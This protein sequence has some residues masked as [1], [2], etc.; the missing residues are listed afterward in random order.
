MYFDI[1][2]GE[3]SSIYEEVESNNRCINDDKQLYDRLAAP[4]GPTRISTDSGG[5]CTYIGV[6]LPRNISYETSAHF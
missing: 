3:S 2:E 1:I 4:C 6:Q 5:D